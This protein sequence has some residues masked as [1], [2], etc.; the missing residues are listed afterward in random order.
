MIWTR[1]ALYAVV[2]TVVLVVSACGGDSDDAP[3]TVE[4]IVSEVTGDL[5]TVESLVILDADG[6]SH[7]FKPTPGLLFYGGPL[8][9]LRDH[10]VTGQRVAVTFE[11]GAYGESVAVLI[12][13][14]EAES[15][16]EHGD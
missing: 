10:V 15:A 7:L 3:D 12:E 9:H 4:G 11:T 6:N 8:S 2:A 14:T 13:H 5:T 16:H 1:K